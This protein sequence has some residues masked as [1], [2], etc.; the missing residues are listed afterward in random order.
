MKTKM[1]NINLNVF[2]FSFFISSFTNHFIMETIMVEFLFY[3]KKSLL[4]FCF[5]FWP[6]LAFRKVH[7]HVLTFKIFKQLIIWAVIRLT[8]RRS[9]RI[10]I[11]ILIHRRIHLLI[12][13]I[14]PFNNILIYRL[15]A[16]LNKKFRWIVIT[17]SSSS[18]NWELLIHKNIILM[19]ITPFLTHNIAKILKR[20][21]I[22]IRYTLI[23]SILHLI[24]RNLLLI[25]V[26]LKACSF[27]AKPILSPLPYDGQI[28]LWQILNLLIINLDIALCRRRLIHIMRYTRELF[29][30]NF[31]SLIQT[32]PR[33]GIY[34]FRVPFFFQT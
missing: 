33:I 2:T 7:F 1:R 19:S 23:K 13:A 28:S 25:I 15:F 12:L 5:N 3:F 24:I 9:Y 4:Y 34:L 14:L 8:L 16:L 18:N 27:H 10:H 20:I 32:L 22:A 31:L 6:Q 11:I 30:R 17:I 21:L 26:I 29:L